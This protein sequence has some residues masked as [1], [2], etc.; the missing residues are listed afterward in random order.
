[1]WG[2]GSFQEV[3][4]R[5]RPV[6]PGLVTAQPGTGVLPGGESGD[7]NL[8]SWVGEG[9]TVYPGQASTPY[10]PVL[11]LF[12]PLKCSTTGG[13][14]G[15]RVHPRERRAKGLIVHRLTV[16]K[17]SKLRVLTLAFF[18]FFLFFFFFFFFFAAPMAY[19]SF[20]ARD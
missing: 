4:G 6:D 9:D 3:D 10:S 17:A 12:T 16:T 11:F 5:T 20:Q 2:R 14:L 19:G 7:R 13:L 1:M 15:D 8:C 18:P